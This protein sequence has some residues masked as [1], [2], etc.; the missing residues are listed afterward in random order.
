[1]SYV[2]EHSRHKGS[3][4][5]LMLAIADHA[6]DNGV[7]YPSIPRLAQKM[8][9][10]ER[11]V[12]YR[13]DKLL[14]STELVIMKN[15]GPGGVHLF[16]VKVP[17]GEKIAP[18]G[19]E[20]I[21]PQEYGKERASQAG[22]EKIAPGGEKIA[23]PS[24]NRR[25][26]AHF[27]GGVKPTSPKPSLEPSFLKEEKPP[28]Y[29]PPPSLEDSLG[30]PPEGEVAPCRQQGQDEKAPKKTRFPYDVVK[31]EELRQSILD[32][33]FHAWFF[34][35]GLTLNINEQWERFAGKAMANGYKYLDW[36]HAFMNWLVS[37]YQQASN[38]RVHRSKTRDEILAEAE[39]ILARQAQEQEAAHDP[40]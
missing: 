25:G 18:P 6:D 10:S 37:D 40:E 32:D 17:G 15:A 24:T 2:W 31:Q 4:L 35:K 21:A 34:K 12:Q 26:E 23:P 20:K 33:A 5:L 36:R 39:A 30:L 16:Q 8:R 29:I 13:L 27:T 14:N 9:M 11:N 3:D 7:A 38:G 22:G 28:P 1:M 19:G